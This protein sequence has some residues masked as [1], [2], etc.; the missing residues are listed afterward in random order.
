MRLTARFRNSIIR[1]FAKPFAYAAVFTAVLAAVFAFTLLDAFVIPRALRAVPPASGPASERAPGAWP[2]E[3]AGDFGVN[4]ADGGAGSAGGSGGTADGGGGSDAIAGGGAGGTADGAGAGSGGTADAGADSA[5]GSGRT[6]DGGSGAADRFDAANGGSGAAGGSTE[7]RASA[8]SPGAA[9]TPGRPPDAISGAAQTPGQPQPPGAS[10]DAA[11]GGSRAVQ[12]QA[13]E[14]T[15]ASYK[16]GNIS[17]TVETVRA[18]DTDIYIADITLSGAGYLKTAFAQDTYGR[19]IKEDTS[20]IAA[21]SNA[22]FA[23]NGDY[24]GFREDGWVL[25]NGVLYRSGS[26]DGALIMDA[27]GDLS[28]ENS[29]ALSGGSIDGLWQIWSFGPPLI[30]DG[31]IS[32]SVNEE[33]SGRS[34]NS[35]PR[36]AIGQAGKL[37][38][39]VVVSDG[40]TR[41]N[42]GLSLYELAELFKERDCSVAYNLDGG[43][44]ST[45]YFDGRVVNNPAT[46]GRRTGEREVSDIVYIGY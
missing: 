23:V 40:R 29:A 39:I 9:H 12:P 18:H 31:E 4:A 30:L 24:Y 17:I 46:G 27:E 28:C 2:G 8:P 7:S 1:F 20:V 6:A 11:D 33:I 3:D 16:D 44:S 32:V 5:D 38:Y 19:N 45:M 13:P 42:A 21:A 37:R 35:N 15:A 34:S 10:S 22:I 25:R 14:I 43:G 41:S 36:T 26:E